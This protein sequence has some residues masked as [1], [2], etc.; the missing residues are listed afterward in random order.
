MDTGYLHDLGLPSLPPLSHLLTD[1]GKALSTPVSV[2]QVM[3]QAQQQYDFTT[4]SSSPSATSLSPVHTSLS[5]IAP[6]PI[7]SVAPS[8]V[9][10]MGMMAPATMLMD[11]T[12]AMYLSPSQNQLS[13]NTTS[14]S[15]NTAAALMA[16]T[17]PFYSM[18]PSS[19]PASFMI[20][21]T[22]SMDPRDSMEK[23]YSFVAIPGSN[24]RKRPRRRYDEIERLYHCT[25]PHCSKS[26]GTLN[27]LNAHVSMQKHVSLT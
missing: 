9:S 21:S 11:P 14:S 7:L 3:A 5:M 27:H 17:H 16:T 25:W 24:Q 20:P 10:T 2:A 12:T 26:Y 6:E 4:S 22:D 8:E 18:A 19:P 13:T 1:D 15:N 23:N